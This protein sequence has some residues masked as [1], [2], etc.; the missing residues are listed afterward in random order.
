MQKIPIY[1]LYKYVIISSNMMIDIQTYTYI[2]VFYN[3]VHMIKILLNRL[4]IMYRYPIC[5]TLIDFST[6][7]EYLFQIMIH[8]FTLI[9]S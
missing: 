4:E 8:T 7:C 2:M 9:L 3:I 6:E 5:V 1:N